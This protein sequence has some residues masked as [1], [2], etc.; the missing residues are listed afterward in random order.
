M[1]FW[2]IRFLK[3]ITKLLMLIYYARK[4]IIGRYMRCFVHT[5]LT[6]RRPGCAISCHI[7]GMDPEPTKY[8]GVAKIG[9]APS[10]LAQEVVHGPLR[11]AIRASG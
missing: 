6:I 9:L 10:T 5:S 3:F 7:I 1:N 4:W 8:R 2:Q 11:N